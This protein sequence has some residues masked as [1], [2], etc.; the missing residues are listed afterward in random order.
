V[1]FASGGI[2]REKYSTRVPFIELE[3]VQARKIRFKDAYIL[4][5]LIGIPATVQGYNYAGY[6]ALN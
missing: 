6:H 3:E 4:M 2:I 1:Y 5:T